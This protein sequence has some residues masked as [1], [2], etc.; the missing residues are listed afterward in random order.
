MSEPTLSPEAIREVLARFGALRP[1]PSSDWTGEADLPPSLARYYADVGPHGEDGPAGPEGIVIPTHGNEFRLP[2]LR[3]LWD[4]QAGYRWNGRTGERLAD[5]RDEWLVVADQGGDPFILDRT[6]GAILHARHGGGAWEPEPI[7]ADVFQ[8]AMAL[9]TFG[10]VYREAG[11]DLYDADFN[12]RP[13]WQE[14]M[15]A[16]LAPILEPG[17]GETV[18]ALLDW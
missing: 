7:F 6:A 11:D 16:R 4:M 15:R 1:Q 13:V 5:W 18:A 12:I 8:M 2:P 17:E 10:I 9:G 14:T 3:G